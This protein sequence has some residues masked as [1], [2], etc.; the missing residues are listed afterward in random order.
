MSG[1]TVRVQDLLGFLQGLFPPDLAEDWDNVG[2][3]VGDPMAPVERVLI[4]LDPGMAVVDAAHSQGAQLLVT[5]HPLLF[6]P[7]RRLTPDDPVGRV[8][9]Q[10]VR[11]GVAIVAVHT[12]LDAAADGLNDWLAARLSL[13]EAEP[14]QAV[15]GQLLKLVVF[16]PVEHVDAVAEAMFA[17]GAGHIGGYD[18]CSFQTSG[19]GTF[20]PGPGT[21]PFIGESGRR[22]RVEEVRLETAVTRRRLPQVLEKL[23]KAHPYEEVAYDL[24]PLTNQL[25]GTGLGRI[26]RLA[27]PL[28]LA[29]LAERVKM[30]L[31]CQAVRL[32]GVPDRMIN[33]VAVCGGSGAGL[34]Q[35]AKRRGAE[36][37][38]TGDVKYH[39][40]R[41][42]E[43][44]GLALLDAGHFAT[45]RLA[46]SEL[47]AR[48]GQ[49]ATTRGWR[50]DVIVHDGEHDPFIIH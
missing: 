4:A 18:Q 27:E 11:T 9:W 48:L 1:R 45:E 29:A 36:V 23:M 47:A 8:V 17:A 46:V 14:L 20:R 39:E 24:V 7:L 21:S 10:A 2:L 28:V 38:V 3:Q 5:H 40:A 6:K 43:D 33:K 31:N 25:P 37:L 35:E 50:L 42:A 12:N 30:V 26:G 41:L 15:T 34:I 22:E 32:V 19:I 16:V 44:L 13:A 49:E